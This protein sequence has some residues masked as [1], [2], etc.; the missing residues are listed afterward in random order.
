ML[1]I[2]TVKDYEYK[3]QKQ[4]MSGF[5]LGYEREQIWRFKIDMST[6]AVLSSKSYESAE[7]ALRAG[8][9]FVDKLLS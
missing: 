1:K 7:K 8:K 9:R 5:H 2:S 4:W 3:S 6:Q